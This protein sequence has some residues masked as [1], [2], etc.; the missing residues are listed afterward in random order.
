MHRV[1]STN[2]LQA[3]TVVRQRVGRKERYARDADYR[4]RES[5]RRRAYHQAHKQEISVRRQGG[6]LKRRYGISRAD[7]VALLKR[8]G[9][10][11]AICGKPSKKTLC[12]DHCHSTGRIRGLLCRKCNFGLGCYAEDQAAMIA[13]LAYLGHDAF[14][15][16][17][18]GSAARRA[19]LARAASPPTRIAVLTEARFD[20]ASLARAAGIGRSNS[21][22]R[23]STR[24]V[25]GP[26][27]NSIHV[28]PNGGHMSIDDVPPDGGKTGRPMWEALAAELQ[29]ESD[30]GE[31]SKADIRRLIA[32]KLAAKALDGDLGSIKEIFD[33]MDGKSVAGAAPDEPPGKV[34]FE[35]KDP[36]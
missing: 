34:V 17:G 5:A 25:A 19:L 15:G 26:V 23:L 11:C 30:D 32:R 24:G 16:G 2:L 20:A 10:V 12:V 35:W 36:E 7:Y 9:G 31:G 4:A 28:Q 27:T 8:Q 33:R 6:H 1:R 22:L 18:S 13:A 21:A 3:Q 14:D 29:H